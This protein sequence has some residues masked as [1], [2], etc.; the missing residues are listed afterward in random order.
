[1]S[2]FRPAL[3]RRASSIAYAPLPA[4]DD[5]DDYVP[6]RP[7]HV[8]ENSRSA[9][10]TRSV[11]S[12]RQVPPRARADMDIEHATSADKRTFRNADG[13]ELDAQQRKMALVSEALEATGMG[14][15]QWSMCVVPSIPCATTRTHADTA[16]CSAASATPSTSRGHRRSG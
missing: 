6:A 11:R 1:M 3:D 5:A 14:R 10:L 9:L 7:S 15:Y 8:R 12:L 16:F 2:A 13:T 4:E